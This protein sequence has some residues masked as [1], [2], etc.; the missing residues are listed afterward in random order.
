MAEQRKW[1]LKPEVKGILI[2]VLVIFSL[3]TA[4]TIYHLKTV[5]IFEDDLA[6]PVVTIDG[7][8]VTLKEISYYIMEVENTGD[9]FARVYNPDNPIEYWSLF[10]NEETSAGY[11]SDLARTAALD[12]C[13]RDNIYY[14]EAVRAGVELTDEEQESVRT[15]AEDYYAQ[16]TERQ[17]K[18]TQ[19]VTED[20]ELIIEKVT[21][22]QKYMIQLSLQEDASVL[23][24][25][26]L[27]YDVGGDYYE[28]LKDSYAIKVNEKIWDQVHPGHITIN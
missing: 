18:V 17:R 12:Y 3:M 6:E 19:L 23:E 22:T 16:M 2:F 21:L 4:V 20:L 9:E 26:A 13:I 25:V 14:L 1:H 11:V 7:T 27:H 24:A 5:F 28:S 15:D 8:V 10:M